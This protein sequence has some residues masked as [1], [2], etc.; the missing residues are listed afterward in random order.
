MHVFARVRITDN[1]MLFVFAV[2]VRSAVVNYYGGELIIRI[3]L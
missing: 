3:K 2:G 1:C